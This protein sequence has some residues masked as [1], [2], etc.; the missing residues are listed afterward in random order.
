MQPLSLHKYSL[1]C[2][3]FEIDIRELQRMQNTL[4]RIVV[5]HLLAARSSELLYILHGLPVYHHTNFKIARFK[6]EILTLSQAYYIGLFLVS[7]QV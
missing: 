1:F 7:R 3:T 6:F 5:C 4:A 2:G